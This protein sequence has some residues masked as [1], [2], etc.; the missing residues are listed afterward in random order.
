MLVFDCREKRG[1]KKG[2]RGEI[3]IEVRRFLGGMGNILP[4]VAVNDGRQKQL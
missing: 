1:R 3:I 2:K 4:L